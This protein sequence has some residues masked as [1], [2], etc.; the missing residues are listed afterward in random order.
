M[1]S[2]QYGGHAFCDVFEVI[3][4]GLAV[5]EQPGSGEV[6][7]EFILFR[8]YKEESIPVVFDF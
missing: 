4:C 5:I 6:F 8:G 3:E 7:R 1:S 2:I